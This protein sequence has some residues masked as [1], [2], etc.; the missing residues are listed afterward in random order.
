M[1]QMISNDDSL[2]LVVCPSH[3]ERERDDILYDLIVVF[4]VVVVDLE[5]SICF[6]EIKAPI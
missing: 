4:L 3:R 5:Q 1:L 2:N 6:V